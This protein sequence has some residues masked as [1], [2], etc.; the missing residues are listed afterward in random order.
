MIRE[1]VLG[2]P[3]FA[4]LENFVAVKSACD[5]HVTVIWNVPYEVKMI[6]VL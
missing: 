2:S 1:D 5:I 3:S 6:I 4:F